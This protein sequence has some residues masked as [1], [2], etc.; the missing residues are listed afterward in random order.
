MPAIGAEVAD[1]YIEVHADTGPFRRE[2]KREATLAAREASDNFGTEFTKAIDRDLD[3]LGARVAQSLRESGEL[4]GRNLME[5][6]A[7]QVRARADRINTAFA[8]SITFGDFAPFIE[9]FNNFDDAI[10]DFD[11]R[12]RELNRDGTLTNETFDRLNASF[13]AYVR[14][15]QDSAIADALARDRAEA[16]EFE[17]A[18]ER[19][20]TSLNKGGD[21]ARKFSIGLG[22]F[23]GSRNDFLNFIGSLSGFLERNIGRG[24]E[25]LFQGVGSGVSFLGRSLSGVNGPLGTVGRK[26]DG[27]GSTINKLGAGGLD[28]LIIQIA[29]LSLGLQ[30]L[31]AVMGPIAA[32]VSGLLAAFTALAVGIGGALLGGI[33]A[34]GPA[35]SALAVGITAVSVGFTGLS[36]R[37]KAVFKPLVELFKVVRDAIQSRLFKGLGDQVNGLLSALG[38]AGPF[39]VDLAGVFR[40]WVN[41]VVR[42]IGPGGPLDATFRSLGR[43]LPVIFRT[44]LDL[45]SAT[46]GALTG[47][48]AG[49]APGAERLFRG[50]TGVVEQFSA[51]VNTR[52]GQQAINQFMQQAV[53]IL[54][55]LWA[56]ATAVGNTLRIMWSGGAVEGAQTLLQSIS[57]IVE[58]MNAWLQTRAGQEALLAFFRNGVSVAEGLGR[59]VVALV[60]LFNA[61]DTQFTRIAFSQIIS[62]LTTAIGWFT[63]L[64]V[65][66]DV[67]I[68]TAANFVGQAIRVAQSLGNLGAR[69][70]AAGQA[71]RSSLVAAFNAVGNLIGSLILR[72][73]SARLSIENFASRARS[74]IA[75]FAQAA[76][77]AAGRVV[78]GLANIG[79][80]ALRA[81]SAFGAAISRGVSTALATL[82]R[83]AVQAVSVLSGLGGRMVSIGLSIMQGLYNGVV[84]GAGRVLSF[85]RGLAGEV[86]STFARVLGIA[87][88]SKIFRELGGFTIDGLIQGMERRKRAAEKEAG[89]VAEGVINAAIRAFS[90]QQ[91]RIDLAS[92]RV[93]EALAEAG[94][95]P[96][97]DKVFN[98]LGQRVIVSL[99]NGLS[100]GR[101]AAQ[102]DVQNIMEAIG[103]TAER[104]MKGQDRRTRIVIAAQA[105]SLRAWVRG[106]ASALD[107][108]WREVDRANTRLDNAR[109]RLQTLQEDYTRLR[110]QTL[111]ALRS[112]LDLGGGIQDDGTA[113]F[114]SVSSQVSGL[115]ARMKKFAGLIKKLIKAGFPPALVQEVA[116][117]G[118]TEGITVANALLSGTKAQQKELISDFQSIQSASS[119]I[120]TALADQMYQSGIQAQKGLIRGLEANRDAL[121]KAARRIAKAITDEIKRELGIKSPSTVFRQLGEFIAEGLALGIESGTDRVT[122]AVTGLVNPNA[123]SNVNAPIS[124][125]A[126]GQTASGGTGTGV[127]GGIAAGA[128]QIVTPYANPRLVALEVMDELAARGK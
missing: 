88:P 75:G 76:V 11:T 84:S 92:Q 82:G 22:T 127:V 12:L 42:E 108:V 8:Q 81:M 66:T 95:N 105:K 87:S 73:T 104:A 115:A 50:I 111:Q 89:N 96:R 26:L 63:R 77:L 106:Q 101:A 78:V 52:E 128:I 80:S 27:F 30:A 112:E 21:S 68:R 53:D 2:L 29:A 39:L 5:G 20:I 15:L 114:E 40:G 102:E 33:L 59:V 47:L 10:E 60:G 41:D 25:R 36:K 71:F 125:L 94:R 100:R 43:D 18:N 109:E 32:G 35:M 16:I 37:Q 117:L 123:L 17:R 3:P 65:V 91:D 79:T 44:L 70:A 85:I 4:G 6:I 54:N 67:M 126:A 46:G 13:N 38:A 14:T 97:L 28:G 34:L 61:L 116:A 57:G 110:T 64:A 23:K 122:G 107:A 119:A 74:V 98:Q 93:F 118:T 99:T 83:F 48:F 31:V 49:A 55:D 113:T 120:G 58:R 7:D 90:D 19:L 51:W 86:A 9:S 103:K 69:A 72:F 56:I 124:S 1:A 24:L 45:I 62:F 121:L